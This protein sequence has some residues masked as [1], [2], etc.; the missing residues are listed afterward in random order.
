MKKK[1]MSK[2]IPAI[3]LSIF[4][5]F[6]LVSAEERIK[7]SIVK[8]TESEYCLQLLAGFKKFFTDKN[9]AVE[10]SEY[11][12][13]EKESKFVWEKIR[14]NKPDVI[15]TI[16]TL[17]TKTIS[18]NFEEIP[19]VFSM[20]LEPNLIAKRPNVSGV[21]VN[22]PLETKFKYLGKILPKAKRIG[23]IYSAKTETLFSEMVSYSKKANY[24]LI[25]KKIVSAKELPEAFEDLS[26]RIDTLLM[27]PDPNIYT[28]NSTKYIILECLRNKINLMGISSP[29]T[30]A[31][32]LFSLDCDY[33]DIGKQ[34]GETALRII[35][36]EKP[37]NIP[38]VSPRNTRLYLNLSTAENIGVTITPEVI[39]ETVEILGR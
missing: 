35:R 34:A 38:L 39:K 22:I 7:I 6:S 8:T 5:T 13:E 9:T 28:I 20:V 10:F 23:V 29:Y 36:G 17:A 25:G 32:A 15:F 2:L 37:N 14:N 21:S 19:V 33:E 24:Q 18:D 3:L 12:L 27:I 30:K 4:S 16:G 31:G 26:W 11:T 1:K